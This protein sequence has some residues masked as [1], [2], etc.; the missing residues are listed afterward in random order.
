MCF[1]MPMQSNPTDLSQ[2]IAN[3]EAIPPEK[4]TW[5]DERELR[6][7]R[8]MVAA[9]EALAPK[10]SLGRPIEESKP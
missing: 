2:K 7:S 5:S 1:N 6:H 10:D 3:L 9:F 8:L 4:R